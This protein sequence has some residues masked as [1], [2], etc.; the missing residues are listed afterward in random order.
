MIRSLLTLVVLVS[1]TGA[2]A[3]KDVSIK[4]HGQS[5]FEIKSSAG[6][7]IAIDPH[8]ID[9]YGRRELKPDVVLFSHFHIDHFAPE[10]IVNYA[11]V[12]K[13]LGLKNKDYKE[14]VTTGNRKNDEFNEFK[15]EVKDVTIRCIGAYHDKMQGMLRGKT[16]IFIL[17]VD[18]LKI[19]HLG[20]LGHLLTPAQ[21][22]AI[23]PVDILM[24]P[25]GG[26]YAL[27]GEDAREVVAQ[28]KPR[29]FILPMHYGTKVYDYLLDEK[30]FLEDQDEKRIKKYKFNELLVDPEE[31]PRPQPTIALLNYE[32]KEK[33]EDK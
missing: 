21:I 10:P 24:I 29:R 12:K 30:E 8:N 23:G 11:K 15:E 18:G 28:L 16:G 3:A 7:V 26:V 14:G 13:L 25:V 2:A 32:Q 31:A 19:V 17:E 27:N 20:D 33:K 5:F 4:W 6:T 1:L 22:K 9:A